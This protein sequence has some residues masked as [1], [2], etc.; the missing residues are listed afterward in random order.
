MNQQINYN[1]THQETKWNTL[2][3]LNY[4]CTDLHL[5]MPSG[6]IRQI[7]V[8]SAFL[9]SRSSP[10]N[11]SRT[12]KGKTSNYIGSSPNLTTLRRHTN[13]RDIEVDVGSRIS[14]E[15]D[16]NLLRKVI[17][18]FFDILLFF[19]S[20]ATFPIVRIFPFFIYLLVFIFS[21]IDFF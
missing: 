7:P 13:G 16:T 2:S 10:N 3:Y 17:I 9:Q 5:S 11:T 15:H 21:S 19:F 4:L 12:R 6:K 1:S 14:S 8:P 20:I 18:I